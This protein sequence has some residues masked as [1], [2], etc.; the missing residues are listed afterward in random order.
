MIDI[1]EYSGNIK[2]RLPK[3][4]HEMLVNQAEKEGVSLNQLCLMYLSSSLCGTSLGSDKF[5]R[6]LYKTATK[7]NGNVDVLFTEL[8]KLNDMVNALK[9]SLLIELKEAIESRKRITDEYIDPLSMI[10]PIYSGCCSSN[11]L[12]FLKLPSAKIVLEPVSRGYLDYKEI[13][14]IVSGVSSN[15]VVAYGDYDLYRPLEERMENIQAVHRVVIN[16]CCNFKEL[17]T[18][19]EAAKKLLLESNLRNEFNIIVKPCYLHINTRELLVEKY[20]DL[21]Y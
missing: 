13:E 7:S 2:L 1:K 18:Q 19:V 21:L 4:L 9:P 17:K 20:P 12:P 14:K 10:Y 11:K 15:I 6:E 16:F 3:S 5:N 8:E